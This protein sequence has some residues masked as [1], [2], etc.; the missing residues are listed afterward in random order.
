MDDSQASGSAE[1]Q[2]IMSRELV[3]EVDGGA[4]QLG[5]KPPTELS[6]DE[7]II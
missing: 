6:K 5:S 4:Q 2:P 1:A 3:L 7:P